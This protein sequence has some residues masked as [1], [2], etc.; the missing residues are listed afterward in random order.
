MNAPLLNDHGMGPVWMRG[1]EI[2]PA[3]HLP[4]PGS[5]RFI[6]PLTPGQQ[7]L[8]ERNRSRFR[9]AAEVADVRNLPMRVAFKIVSEADRYV[10]A[11]RDGIHAL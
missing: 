5:R 7:R 11:L 3:P 9:R 8:R 10:V 1:I 2:E 4:R 6:G